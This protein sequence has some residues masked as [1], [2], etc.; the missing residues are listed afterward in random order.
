MGPFKAG[1]LFCMSHDDCDVIS[2][3][4]FNKLDSLRGDIVSYRTL[5]FRLGVSVAKLR[6]FQCQLPTR[7][8]RCAMAHDELAA[9][10]G[11]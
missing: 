11:P 8:F 4:F 10:P 6:L 7:T 5:L 3:S 2:Q 9:P 1:F